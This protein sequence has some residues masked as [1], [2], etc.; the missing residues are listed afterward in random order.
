LA[1]LRKE[2][3]KES[4][5]EVTRS[6]T[7]FKGQVTKLKNKVDAI[8]TGAADELRTRELIEPTTKE[9]IMNC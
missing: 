5:L 4:K 1:S 8:K 2:F 7:S 6:K 9:S 3:E